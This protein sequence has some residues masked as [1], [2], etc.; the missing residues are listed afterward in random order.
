MPA[1]K[2]IVTVG[3]VFL[4]AFATGYVMQNA[5]ALAARFGV[6]DSSVSMENDVAVVPPEAAPAEIPY[7]VAGIVPAE[8]PIEQLGTPASLSYVPDLPGIVLSPAP[9]PLCDLSVTASPSPAAMVELA[10]DGACHFD[11][12]ILIRHEGLRFTERL[13]GEGKAE[14]FVPALAETA[15]FEIEAPGGSETRVSVSVPDAGRYERV[16]LQWQG[17]AGLALHAFEFGASRGHPGHIHAGN[18]KSPRRARL[19]GAG[20]LT[21]LGSESS[22]HRAQVY[23]FPVLGARSDGVVRM[24][25]ELEVTQA[26]CGKEIMADAVRPMAGFGSE[27]MEL[28]FS[29]PGCDSIGQFLVL[30]NV[31]RDMKIAAN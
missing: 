12:T 5:D 4:V 18:P 25:V 19:T 11:E 29:V 21:E 3:S 27:P 9:E 6:A 16:A 1:N 13:D 28:S 23:S 31:L 17:D 30:N 20:F 26:N 14:L 7:S 8:R 24:S 22:G 2:R 10:I 15:G